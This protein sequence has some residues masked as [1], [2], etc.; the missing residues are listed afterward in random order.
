[1]LIELEE[2]FKSRWRK[3]YLQTHPNGRQYICLF[4]DQMDRTLIS[5]ARYQLSVKEGK[6][7]SS[8]LDADHIDDDPTND[9]PDN[10]QP[11]SVKENIRKAHVASRGFLTSDIEQR[12]EVC[13]DVFFNVRIRRTCGKSVC[14]SELFRR[15]SISLGLR[16]PNNK[17]RS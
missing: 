17:K 16:P 6:F 7:L 5:C 4:N 13:K 9:S 3:G 2:P 10:V 15:V 14:K 12:C 1:M 11:L 8:E